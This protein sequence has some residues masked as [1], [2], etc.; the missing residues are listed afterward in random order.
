[1]SIESL[2]IPV[3]YVWFKGVRLLSI[4]QS[5]C[6]LCYPCKL[7]EHGAGVANLLPLK[8]VGAVVHEPHGHQAVLQAGVTLLKHCVDVTEMYS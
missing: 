1:M 3:C 5:D 8:E 2:L 4:W 6:R 7:V